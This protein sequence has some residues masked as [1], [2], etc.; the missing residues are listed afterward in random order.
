[1]HITSW[2]YNLTV[3]IKELVKGFLKSIEKNNHAEL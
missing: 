3:Q 1:M 2:E